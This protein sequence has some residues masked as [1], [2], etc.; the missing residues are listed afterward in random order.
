MHLLHVA[1]Q[2][3][4]FIITVC[5]NRLGEI[6]C[7]NSANMVYHLFKRQQQHAAHGDP[8]GDNHYNHQQHNRR[9]D[10]QDALVVAFIVLDA[11]IGKHCLRFAPFTIY[12]LHR[13]LFLFGILLEHIFQI[14]L[15]QQNVHLRQRCRVNAVLL[16]ELVGQVL[17]QAWRVRQGIVFIVMNLRFSQQIFRRGHQLIQLTA[18]NL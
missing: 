8:A 13:V 12:R 7:R 1:R 3:G 5:L 15:A 16:F 18:V 17:I 2:D 6:A 14:A 11:F 9:K 10:P 4:H